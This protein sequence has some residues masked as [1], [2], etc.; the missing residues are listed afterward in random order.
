MRLILRSF[1]VMAAALAV[2]AGSHATDSSTAVPS[3]AAASIRKAAG[4]SAFLPASLP[5]GYRYASWKNENPNGTANAPGAPLFVVKFANGSSQLLWTVY[6]AT[7]EAE[8]RCNA[9]SAGHA[10]VGGEVVY[11]S[12]LTTYDRLGTGPKGRH[13]WRCVNPPGGSSR[14]ELDAFDQGGNQAIP[15][16]SRIV[17][18][19]SSK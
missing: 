10:A 18:Q 9:L 5:S 6:V 3:R 11:W 8:N 17:A 12:A 14:I 2:A 13:V 19:A 1:V 4:P 16:L 7:N 15:L